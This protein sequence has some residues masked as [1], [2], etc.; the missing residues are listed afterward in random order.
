MKTSLMKTTALA[1]MVA[2]GSLA[3]TAPAEAPEIPSIV[4]R[5]SSRR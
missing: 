2:I 5:P 4:S 3:L 1:A